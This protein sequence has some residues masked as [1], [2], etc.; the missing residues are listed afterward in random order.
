MLPPSSKLLDGIA[1]VVKNASKAVSQ[2]SSR[3]PSR[4]ASRIYEDDPRE[5]S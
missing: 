1:G 2:L 3:M 5:S 4:R